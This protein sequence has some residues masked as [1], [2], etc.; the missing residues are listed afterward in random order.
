MC[1]GENLRFSHVQPTLEAVAVGKQQ[2]SRSKHHDLGRVMAVEAVAQR[3]NDDGRNAVVVERNLVLV[4]AFVAIN[5]AG[6]DFGEQ[7]GLT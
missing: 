2:P 1:L 7:L 4:L 5:Q 6:R 3:W